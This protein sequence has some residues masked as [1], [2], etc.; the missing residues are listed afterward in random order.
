[1]NSN[2]FPMALE[3]WFF[4]GLGKPTKK[5][6]IMRKLQMRLIPKWLNTSRNASLHLHYRPYFYVKIDSIYVNLKISCVNSNRIL[7]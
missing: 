5:R 6:K 4:W 2:I 1:M 3:K 7:T